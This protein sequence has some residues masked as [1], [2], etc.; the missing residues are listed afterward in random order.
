MAGADYGGSRRCICAVRTHARV[1]EPVRVQAAP[2][3]RAV[4]GRCAFRRIGVLEL[5]R[6]EETVYSMSGF[7]AM[8]LAGV[9]ELVPA[10]APPVIRVSLC[11]FV[12]QASQSPRKMHL[13]ARGMAEGNYMDITLHDRLLSLWDAPPASHSPLLCPLQGKSMCVCM[14]CGTRKIVCVCARARACVC[15]CMYLHL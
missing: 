11:S 13:P 4:S 5:V 7:Q 15:V 1:P 12:S 10:Q 14:Y 8:C 6:Q 3:I 2:V 9:P